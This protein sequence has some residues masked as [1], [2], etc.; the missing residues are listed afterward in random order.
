[1]AIIGTAHRGKRI[2][3]SAIEHSAVLETCEYLRSHGYGITVL[4]VDGEGM[5]DPDDLRKA[6]SDDVS[7]VSIMTANNVIGSIQKIRELS[8]IAHEY[9]AYFHTDA[10]QAFTKTDTDVKRSGADMLSISAHKIHGPKGV[11]ALYVKDGTD[12]KPIMFGGGQELGIRPTTENVPGIVGLGKACEIAKDTMESDIK[13]MAEQR[14]RIIDEVLKIKGS[15]L[16]GPRENRLC[17]NAHFR[18]DGLKGTDLV[19]RLSKEGVAA[20]AA[21][22]CSAGSMEPSHVMTA[23]GLSPEQAFSALRISLSR[24]TTDK[25][26]DHLLAVL[27]NVIRDMGQ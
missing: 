10:V 15:A 4:K 27:P 20:S 3:T 24:Y 9:G 16:N 8:D 18:F 11:G 25:E 19:L 26:I 12:I 6:M 14:D 17:N 22:A 13:R 5:V 2:I 23:I 21:S 1:M 7:S